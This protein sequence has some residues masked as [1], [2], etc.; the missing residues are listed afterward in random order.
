M[1]IFSL[2]IAFTLN[3]LCQ[4]TTNSELKKNSAY[5]LQKS[6]K[7]KTMAWAMLGVGTAT[8]VTGILL[9]AGKVNESTW[10][11]G[12]TQKYENTGTKVILYILGGGLI[13]T[14]IGF[15]DASGKNKYRALEASAFINMEQTQG[16][17]ATIIKNQSFPVVSVNI[18]IKSKNIL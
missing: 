12:L 4:Q 10:Q 3:A 5:Y 2:A 14:S 17:Q 6:K 11:I 18:K 8:V 1:L 16:L 7:Q 13:G 9:P 15:F